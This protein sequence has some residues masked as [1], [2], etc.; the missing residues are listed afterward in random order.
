MSAILGRSTPD[1]PPSLRVPTCT[2]TL[3]PAASSASVFWWLSSCDEEKAASLLKT[4]LA[5]SALGS[6]GPGE[7]GQAAKLLSELAKR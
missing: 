7:L 3:H 2:P 4:Q 5:L 1:S 6:F